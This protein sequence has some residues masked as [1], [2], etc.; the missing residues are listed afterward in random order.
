VF[1]PKLEPY[2]GSQRNIVFQVLFD[3]FTH[4][5]TKTIFLEFIQNVTF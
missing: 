3:V 4:L 2:Q 1:T 5:R